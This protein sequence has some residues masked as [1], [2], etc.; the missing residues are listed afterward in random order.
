M[1]RFMYCGDVNFTNNVEGVMMLA[2]RYQINELKEMCEN[3]L[4]NRVNRCNA[5][6]LYGLADLYNC[7][8]LKEAVV[9]TVSYYLILNEHVTA[10]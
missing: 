1:V 3:Y 9:R 2:E 5:I 7:R 8:S 10:C 4:C 6:E